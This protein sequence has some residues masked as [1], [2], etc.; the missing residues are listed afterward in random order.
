MKTTA[1]RLKELMIEKNLTPKD[2]VELCQ[3]WCKKYN[4]RLDKSYLSR[5]LSGEVIPKQRRLTILALALETNEGYLIGYD[6]SKEPKKGF[7]SRELANAEKMLGRLDL[8]DLGRI[9]AQMEIMLEADKY[10]DEK[11]LKTA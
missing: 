11:D 3:P 8:Y 9:T 5:Y 4:Q 6:V 10:K 7:K 1:E 2:V